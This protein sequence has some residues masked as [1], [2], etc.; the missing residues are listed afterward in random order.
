MSKKVLCIGINDYPGT[1]LDLSG[2]VN[3]A[4]DWAQVL[5]ERGYKVA[6][7]LD[8]AATKA[9][10]VAAIGKLIGGARAGDL[11][12]ITYS[13]HGTYQPDTDGDEADGLD[14][15]LCPHD[16]KKAGALVDDEIRALFAARK[17]G[18]RLLLI[19]D[20]CHS[21]TVTRTAP[22]APKPAGTRPRFMP[23]GD[24]LPRNRLPRTSSGQAAS[25]IADAPRSVSPL[26]GGLVKQLGD[27]LL[28]GCQEGPNN[29]SYDA[30]IDGRANGAFTHYAL[31]A[32]RGL[33]PGA[34]YAEWH[35]AIRRYLPAG[36]YPQTPQ[37][38]GNAAA[39]KRKALA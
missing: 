29:Y 10:M 18:V 16:I 7:L 13:G 38:V 12:A 20:S 21:G 22:A 31:K 14:E 4:H 15:G 33:D 6:T 17:T 37:L 19:S 25:R 23:M 3:D 11:V 39:R 2:C 8:G 26:A 35:A 5:A 34:T 36:E 28:A 1:K 30:V 9:A 27:V 24:W 32:L